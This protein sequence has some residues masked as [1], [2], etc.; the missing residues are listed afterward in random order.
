M[1]KSNKKWLQL[2][3]VVGD[4]YLFH[5]TDKQCSSSNS[6]WGIYSSIEDGIIYLES[7]TLNL[8]TFR[9]W[10]RLPNKYRYS[11]RATRNELRDYM[12]NMGRFES[13]R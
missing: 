13:K 6:L 11:R 7:S 8:R 2:D 9:L 4:L 5:K 10:H 3:F 1:K 12:Y